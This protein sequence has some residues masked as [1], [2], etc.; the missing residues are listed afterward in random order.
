MI[1]N[2]LWKIKKIKRKKRTGG[3]KREKATAQMGANV[4]ARVF[5]AGHLARSQFASGRCCDRA[6]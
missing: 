4:R 2:T 3:K 6:T 5:N 1:K